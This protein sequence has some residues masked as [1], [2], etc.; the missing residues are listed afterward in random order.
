MRRLNLVAL[1]FVAGCEA[2]PPDPPDPPPPPPEIMCR[3]GESVVNGLC[4]SPEEIDAAMADVTEASQDP[5]P[6][7]TPAIGD[8]TI[9]TGM[10]DAGPDQDWD[11]YV[12]E[13][14]AGDTFEIVLRSLGS[15][16]LGFVVT[17]PNDYRRLS[18]LY[19]QPEPSRRVVL[20]WAGTY[21]IAIAPQVVIEELTDAGPIGGD[22]YRYV[23]VLEHEMF[24]VPSGVPGSGRLYDL[25][26]NLHSIPNSGEGLIRVDFGPI[27]ADAQPVLMVFG[28]GGSSERP[29]EDLIASE[30]LMILMDWVRLVGDD[31]G[32]SI[33]AVA[34]A[35]TTST[36]AEIAG[37]GIGYF[38]APAEA[39]TIVEIA[40]AG[41][42]NPPSVRVLAPDGA[43]LS[44]S[45]RF[46]A[47]A[48]ADYI[49]EVK[50]NDADAATFSIALDPVQPVSIGPLSVGTATG[51]LWRD[52]V[53]PLDNAWF[54]VSATE[55]IAL[56]LSARQQSTANLSVFVYDLAFQPL[57]ELRLAGTSPALSAFLTEVDEVIVEIVDS[58]PAVP[59]AGLSLQV[60][61][62]DL[63]PLETE[64]NDELSDATPLALDAP[65]SGELDA[66][67]SDVYRIDLAAALDVD[68]MLEVRAT[69]S[70][71]LETYACQLLDATAAVIEEQTPRVKGCVIFAGGLAAGDYYFAIQKTGPLRVYSV[72]A[73][74]V[75]GVE[76]VE[77]NDDPPGN[78]I[79]DRTATYGEVATNTDADVFTFQLEND[80][81][82]TELL[83]VRTE[84]VGTRPTSGMQAGL[85]GPGVDSSVFVAPVGTVVR[86]GAAAG[87]YRVRISRNSGNPAFDGL[88]RIAVS[89][90]SAAVTD[91]E[92]NDIAEQAQPLGELPSTAVG[93]LTAPAT[94]DDDWFSFE[95]AQDLALG[96]TLAIELHRIG[97]Q[98]TDS[99]RVALFDPN[100]GFV[101]STNTGDPRRIVQT[102]LVRGTYTVRIDSTFDTAI[103][104]DYLLVVSLE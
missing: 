75:L 35:P 29:V 27:G 22:E 37:G 1:L 84:V 19:F 31:D 4:L 80:L 12:F 25:Q 99:L 87:D 28:E 65:L 7:P 59:I 21:T 88:Y 66:T 70:N 51:A 36:T 10:I 41:G 24:P 69:E 47:E 42:A 98:P 50:N 76:E 71:D 81:G 33:D 26:D 11:A 102:G 73:S 104:T 57:R 83:T 16:E 97:T 13:A 55:P 86:A 91:L 46:Y 3:E 96:E 79:D 67:D 15:S 90:S 101:V 5:T 40:I 6:L 72:A 17:G 43:V 56:D 60:S 54:L 20:P 30:D 63:P 95:L 74:I 34:V 53:A 58:S 32:Y 78:A 68:E 14:A 62:I 77:P 100:Q 44:P 61:A 92:P 52:E 103:D 48:A 82:A 39:G 2:D 94:G 38:L 49:V 93:L 8:S 64:P 18:P 45:A 85:Q 89:T 23:A 9:F